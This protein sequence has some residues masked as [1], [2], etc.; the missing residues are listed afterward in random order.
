MGA[1]MIRPVAFALLSVVLVFLVVRLV[2][3][4]VGGTRETV[5]R[6]KDER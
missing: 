5:F 4:P 2:V 1:T 3:G 6:L